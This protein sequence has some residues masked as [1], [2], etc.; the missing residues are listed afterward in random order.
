MSLQNFLVSA[1]IKY[2]Q[3]ANMKL[4]PEHRF[5]RSRKFMSLNRSKVPPS[6][7]VKPDI[8]AGVN[9][10]WVMP[11]ELVDDVLANVCIYFHGG[12]YVF[13]GMNS[14]RDMA[15]YLAKKA[16]IKMLMV[17]YRLAPEHPFPA[18][19]VDAMAVYKGLINK[20]MSAQKMV[21]AGDSAGGNLALCTLQDIRDQN[22]ALPRACFFFSPWLDLSHSNQSFNDNA[23]KDVILNK[24]ILDEAVAMY[25]PQSQCDDAKISPILASVDNL[26]S[27]LII[28]SSLEVLVEDAKSLHEKILL[29]GGQSKYLQW[30]NTPH[31]FP[32][33]TRLLP[34]AR[35]ALDKTAEFINIVL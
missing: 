31:A 34:E 19:Q 21:M 2:K 23:E 9:V 5:N 28:A 32:V 17:D 11:Y 8:I 6:I 4:S 3:K 13:G 7:C 25:A 1:V 30:K 14:H 24:Q 26:P 27:A 16:N 12:A 10:E 33:L 35:K 29:K 18:A 22:L 15:V 20:G